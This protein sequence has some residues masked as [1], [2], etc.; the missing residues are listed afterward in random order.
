MLVDVDVAGVEVDQQHAD[1]EQHRE[2][3]PDR[4]VG[5]DARGSPGVRS[6]TL[7]APLSSAAPTIWTGPLCWWVS[8]QT[9]TMPK[10]DRVA[11]RVGQHAASAQHQERA[12]QRRG[13]PTSAP[14]SMIIRPRCRAG[15][16]AS[17]L[18]RPS[19]FRMRRPR[20]C[21][22]LSAPS[23]RPSPACAPRAGPARGLEPPDRPGP[24]AVVGADHPLLG[25]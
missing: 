12:D 13:E 4:G 2:H 17:G 8:S 5:L 1:R 14:V 25:W 15:P 16:R 7:S 23:G 22:P 19:S 3:Q 9:T 20:R 11:D 24:D 6:K 18:L 21:R 10:H